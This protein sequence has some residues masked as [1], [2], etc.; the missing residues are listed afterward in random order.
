MNI[1][2]VLRIVFNL[3]NVFIMLCPHVFK[4]SFEELVIR[5]GSIVIDFVIIFTSFSPLSNFDNNN[6]CWGFLPIIFIKIT[7]INSYN[8]L[9]LILSLISS[10]QLTINNSAAL[11][12]MTLLATTRE[13]SSLL[14]VLRCPVDHLLLAENDKGRWWQDIATI[15][16]DMSDNTNHRVMIPSSPLWS[17][18]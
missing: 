6:I 15:H 9:S 1:V 17:L 16:D 18:H 2:H 14:I 3:F 7:V 8:S 10:S 5:S 11:S 12:S 4:M 13:Q